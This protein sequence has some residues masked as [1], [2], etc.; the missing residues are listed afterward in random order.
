MAVKFQIKGTTEELELQRGTTIPQKDDIVF[1]KLKGEQ[2]EKLYTVYSVQ[3]IIDM[4]GIYHQ[5]KTVITLESV[6]NKKG[7]V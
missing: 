1:L 6:K 2:E 5:S 4:S 7:A 3:H